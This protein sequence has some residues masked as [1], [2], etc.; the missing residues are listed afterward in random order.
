[1]HSLCLWETAD[2]IGAMS[3]LNSITGVWFLIEQ[4]GVD[5]EGGT[6]DEV[7]EV[8]NPKCIGLI[9]AMPSNSHEELVEDPFLV[10]IFVLDSMGILFSH[11]STRSILKYPI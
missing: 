6:S 10:V 7:D 11:C 1:M 4:E 9:A 8:D 2:I 5:E 3:R